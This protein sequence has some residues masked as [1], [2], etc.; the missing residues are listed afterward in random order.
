MYELPTSLEVCGVSYEIRSDYRVALDICAALSDPAIDDQE[1]AL[2]ALTILYPDILQMPHE[3]YEEAIRKCF[4]FISCGDEGQNYAKEH[5]LV[6]WNQDF[7]FIVAPINRVCGCEIRE[8]PYM[9]W[10][11][12]IA[13]YYEIGGD[14]TFSQIVRIREKLAKG[15]T[16]D[17][18]DREWYRSNR[19]LVD[20]KTEYTTQE[21]ELCK[22]WGV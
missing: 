12:F 5:K 15:K 11:T 13:A 16:L 10:W 8:M 18:S 2:V 19:H 3:H 14:C 1:R 9:H 17:K 20:F 21:N 22:L 7:R 6:D 4:W